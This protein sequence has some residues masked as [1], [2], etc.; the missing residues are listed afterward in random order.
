MAQTELFVQL[1]FF[2]DFFNAD[3]RDAPEN[4]CEEPG[5]E[6]LPRAH[7]REESAGNQHLECK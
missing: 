7:C 1:D 4:L 6:I 3:I 5:E 2:L